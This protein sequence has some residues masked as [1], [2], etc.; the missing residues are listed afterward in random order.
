M[1]NL[2]WKTVAI[3]GMTLAA[4]L[5][6]Q[7]SAGAKTITVRQAFIQS[8]NTGNEQ[9]VAAF[10]AMDADTG[11]QAL[12]DQ[13][14][15]AAADTAFGKSMRSIADATRDRVHR[16]LIQLAR[17]ADSLGAA[18]TKEETDDI[19][20]QT[21]CCVPQSVIDADI[22]RIDG[23]NNAVNNGEHAVGKLIGVKFRG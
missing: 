22:E 17:D 18:V 12:Q 7:G 23:D 10:K 15:E 9:M 16:A 6:A 1:G 5:G 3:T 21:S 14:S 4:F 19:S 13:E 20:D 11:A 8:V 2:M